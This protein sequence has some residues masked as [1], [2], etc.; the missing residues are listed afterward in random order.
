MSKAY[1]TNEKMEFLRVQGAQTVRSSVLNKTGIS[2]TRLTRNTPNHG[3]VDQHVTE[4]AFM[5]AFQMHDYRGDLWVDGKHVKMPVLRQ[6]Q[7]SFYD[8]NRIWQANMRSEFDC[9][10]FHIP[11]A[12][13]TVLEEDLGTR[14]IETLNIA[15]GANIDDP[16][17]RGLVLALAPAFDSPEQVS[18][19]FL[20]HVGL[21]L[22]THMA[23]RY[24]A[25]KE[26]APPPPGG[27]APWQ[28]R[29]A[30]EM[31]DAQIDG[32]LQVAELAHACHLSPSFFTRAFKLTTGMPPY[33]WMIRRR[34][35][36]AQGL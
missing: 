32:A 8:Y 22:S 21:A 3:Y 4:D 16:T 14:K 6:G 25:A 27:L 7:F 33:Q 36:K 24:G 35:E 18:M 17:V 28:T 34:V 2:A 31:I 1:N 30:T 5:M 26:P 29:R 9:I 15:P 12:S 23:V 10:N 13:I 20:D 19:L 11:R